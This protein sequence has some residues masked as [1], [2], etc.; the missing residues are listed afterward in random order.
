MRVAHQDTK[1]L[2]KTQDPANILHIPVGYQA[3]L[4][5][6]AGEG[7]GVRVTCRGTRATMMLNIYRL[8]R[9]ITCSIVAAACVFAR[10]AVAQ[11]SFPMIISTYPAGVERG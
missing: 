11:T 9:L 10:P 5:P 8:T 7:A 1:S 2:I 6:H 3:P 4:S